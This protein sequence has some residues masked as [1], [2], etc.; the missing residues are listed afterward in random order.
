MLNT[1]GKNAGVEKVYPHRFRHTFAIQ[2]L[3]NGGNV[4]LLKE[5]LGHES[6]EMVM[7]YA[8]IAEQDI[9]NAPA[10]SPADNWRL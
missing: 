5:L 4:A 10:H 9:A 2:F 6:I 8:K 7:R 1:I 3:R